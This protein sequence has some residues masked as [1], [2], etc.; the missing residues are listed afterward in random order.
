MPGWER[1]PEERN[2]YP[3]QYSFLES[4]WT[5]EA[6]ELQFMGSKESDMTE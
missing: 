3:L 5:E 1:S 6:G 2:G 4:S